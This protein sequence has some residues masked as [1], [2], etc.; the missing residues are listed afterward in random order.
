MQGRVGE[1]TKSTPSLGDQV[2]DDE[3]VDE[4]IE[5]EPHVVNAKYTKEIEEKDDTLL[6][7]YA[8]DKRP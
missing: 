4:E 1:D 6:K 2:E 7:K 5:Y 8:K 3:K